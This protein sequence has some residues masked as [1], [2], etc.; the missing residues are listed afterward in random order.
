ME[1]HSPSTQY[2]MFLIIIIVGYRGQEHTLFLLDFFVV[3]L[4]TF[5]YF[6]YI[7]VPCILLADSNCKAM[8]DECHT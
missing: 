1:W 2:R 7:G 4:D 3:D 8:V 6:E 5:L